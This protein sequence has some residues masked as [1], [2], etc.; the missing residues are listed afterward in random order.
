M[1]ADL[2]PTLQILREL[3]NL[4]IPA[5]ARQAGISSKQVRAFEHGEASSLDKLSVLASLLAGLGLTP[6]QFFLA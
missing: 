4:S 1:F 2:G 5:L 6:L 3:R